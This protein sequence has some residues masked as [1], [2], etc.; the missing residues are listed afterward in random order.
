MTLGKV[1]NSPYKGRKVLRVV[2][3]GIP[4]GDVIK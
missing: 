2:G 3:I 4:F 1:A